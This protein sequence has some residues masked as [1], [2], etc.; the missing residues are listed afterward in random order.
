MDTSK[1]KND[2][3]TIFSDIQPKTKIP[4]VDTIWKLS[5]NNTLKTILE[6]QISY[7]LTNTKDLSLYSAQA[8]YESKDGVFSLQTNNSNGG[9]IYGMGLQGDIKNGVSS[10]FGDNTFNKDF[11]VSFHLKKVWNGSI[12]FTKESAKYMKHNSEFVQNQLLNKS[13]KEYKEYFDGNLSPP[14]TIEKEKRKELVKKYEK[15]YYDLEFEKASKLVNASKNWWV[16]GMIYFPVGKTKYLVT[17]EVL[18]NNPPLIEAKYFRKYEIVFDANR[19]WWSKRKLSSLGTLA[20]KITNMNNIILQE[21]FGFENFKLEKFTKAT[22]SE[23]YTFIDST[24]IGRTIKTQYNKSSKDSTFY[25]G[26]YQNYTRITLSPS[27]LF[28]LWGSYRD[29]LPLKGIRFF[30]NFDVQCK[31]KYQ[32]VGFGLPFSF[33]TKDEKKINFEI[34]SVW[35]DLANNFGE[36]KK[37]KDRLSVSLNVGLPLTGFFLND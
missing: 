20:F 13:A 14:D 2:L 16:G 23:S 8:T 1:I 15:E 4:E 3:R 26:A 19:Y 17:N 11:G 30:G 32:E 37:P 24:Q 7:F 34:V 9:Y 18:A 35:K 27:I 21:D 6:N 25:K 5:S 12:Y 22:N 36:Y 31:N 33:K 28:G 29:K 10:I